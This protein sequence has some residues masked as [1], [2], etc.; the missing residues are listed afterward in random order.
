MRGKRAKILRRLSVGMSDPRV[1][2]K[3]QTHGWTHFFAKGS[4]RYTYQKL[5]RNWTRD[6]PLTELYL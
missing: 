4:R 1:S 2:N 3:I 6:L 5:K